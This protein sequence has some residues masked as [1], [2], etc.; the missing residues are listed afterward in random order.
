MTLLFISCRLF[1]MRVRN[2]VDGFGGSDLGPNALELSQT[3]LFRTLATQ[4]VLGPELQ[5]F[6]SI[7]ES[8][9][10]RMTQHSERGCPADF[11]CNCL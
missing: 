10:G 6:C 2:P 3:T 5:A 4:W 8:W 1:L 11:F 7:M 9:L